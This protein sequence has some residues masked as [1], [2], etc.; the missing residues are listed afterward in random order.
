M[1]IEP[2]G[3]KYDITE[4]MHFLEEVSEHYANVHF[5]QD[6]SPTDILSYAERE[7][8]RIPSIASYINR[9][10]GKSGESEM[11]YVFGWECT[12]DV[13][14]MSEWFKLM[15]R[16]GGDI[17]VHRNRKGQNAI[18]VAR[19]RLRRSGYTEEQRQQ[20]ENSIQ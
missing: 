3:Y 14:L 8:S 13:E 19:E 18:E 9:V 6:A 15:H 2:F 4:P 1:T 5:F 20:W 16:L 7:L 17:H 10:G 12:D 11:T